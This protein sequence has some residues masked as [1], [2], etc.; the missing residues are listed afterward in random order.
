MQFKITSFTFL[1]LDYTVLDELLIYASLFSFV[2][3][4]LT[5]VG[6]APLWLLLFNYSS[7]NLGGYT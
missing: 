7:F 4:F 6:I 1:Y 5:L 3:Y 2:N